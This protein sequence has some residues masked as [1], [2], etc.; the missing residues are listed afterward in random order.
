MT[1][2]F[3]YK[4]TYSTGKTCMIDRIELAAIIP[5]E[6]YKT[7][8]RGIADGRQLSEIEGIDQSITAM[9]ESVHS[10]DSYI[11][12]NGKFRDTPLKKRRT[13]TALEFFL[14]EREV[15]NIRRM[16]DPVENLTRP[17]QK[18]T[19]YRNDG[20]SVGFVYKNGEV[21]FSDSKD[22]G[23]IHRM[24]ADAFLSRVIR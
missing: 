19:V 6:E 5:D 22:R 13:I 18:M 14:P 20:S 7:I 23:V 17:E 8:I 16:K 15:Q 4:I 12:T 10:M 3:H 21:T 9:T 11:D 2:H 1:I 24:K